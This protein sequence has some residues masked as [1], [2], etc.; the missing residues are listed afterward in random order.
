[1]TGLDSSTD[2]LQDTT[3][4]RIATGPVDPD[5]CCSQ[6]SQGDIRIMQGLKAPAMDMQPT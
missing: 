3:P 5:F 6:E 1:M 2:L 4:N